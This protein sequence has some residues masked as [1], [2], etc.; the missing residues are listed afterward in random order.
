MIER[1]SVSMGAFDNLLFRLRTKLGK[2]KKITAANVTDIP[3]VINNYNR[4]ACLQQ[5][6]EWLEQA[7][8]RHIFIIDNESAYPP[9]LD[10]YRTT[11]HTVFLLNRN[12]GFTALWK[13]VLFQRFC[14]DYYIYTDPDIIPV[15]EC[16]LTAVSF[17]YELLQKYKTV[18]KVGF[19]LEINDVPDHYPLKGKVQK[20]EA[21]FWSSPVEPNVYA[22]PIDTTFAL[23]RPR[24]A[25]G[26]ELNALRTGGVYRARHLSWYV[27]PENLPEEEL[28]YMQ[29]AGSS[30]S[31]VSELL[32]KER[33]IKY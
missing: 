22:A 16:P 26:S 20:W 13:T 9:L 17:F 25:G 29:H 4:L 18:D 11:K 6:V 33:N 10:Y 21:Q 27:D 7:G 31:W 8:M 19:G 24:V 14:K 28:Y 23:Y 30:S 2:R 3:V 32:G 1:V 15:E 5:Q 12:V